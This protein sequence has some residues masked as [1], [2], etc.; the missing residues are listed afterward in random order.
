MVG[1][2]ENLS[3]LVSQVSI[4]D[5]GYLLKRVDGHGGRIK[6]VRREVRKADL[7]HQQ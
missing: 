3:P 4:S 6:S 1:D 2:T 7:A 5:L